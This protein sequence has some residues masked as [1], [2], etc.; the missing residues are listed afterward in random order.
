MVTT[1]T[2]TTAALF[3]TAAHSVFEIDGDFVG[4]ERLVNDDRDRLTNDLLD[5]AE[6]V[7]LVPHAERQ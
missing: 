6:V 1:A 5:S 2:V 3:H 4:V 7:Q